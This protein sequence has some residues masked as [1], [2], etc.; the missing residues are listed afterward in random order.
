MA[1]ETA[2]SSGLEHH[3]FSDVFQDTPVH[4]QIVQLARQLY[5]WVGV[6][7]SNMDNLCV[8]TPT[9][10]VRLIGV[11]LTVCVGRGGVETYAYRVLAA[12]R[13]PHRR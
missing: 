6:G 12:C 10:L 8:A 9:R 3:L 7:T 1:A 4:F 5:I 11:L 2:S 13:T